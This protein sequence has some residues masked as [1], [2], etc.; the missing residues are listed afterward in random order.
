MS[1]TRIG[2]IG[3]NTGI[4]FA[5]VT[6]IVTLNTANDALSIGATV[7]VGSGNLTVGSG[8]TISSDGD[9]F[10]TGVITATSYSGIDLSDVTGATGDFSIADKIVHTG[11][12]DTAIRFPNTDV[13][14]FETAGA[15]RFSL[16]TNEV[17]VNDPGNDIDFR[18]E[19][20]SDTNLFKVD[21]GNDRIGL[22]VAAPSAKLEVLEDVYVKGSSG[23]GSVGIQIRSGSSAISNQHQIRTGGGSGDQLFIE[24]LGASSAIVSKVA[25][26]ERLRIGPSGQIGIAGANYGT[27]GQV[28]TSGGSG[29]AVSWTTISGTTINANTNNYL[30]TGT[31]TANTLQGESGLTYDGDNLNVS[32]GAHD[33][34]MAITA[35]NNNQ[36]TRLSIIGKASDGTSHTF[37]LNAKRSANRLDIVGGGQTRASI[38]STG[39]FGIGTVAQQSLL[40]VGGGTVSTS[41]KS[42]VHIAPSSGNAMVTLRGGSPQIFFDIT[43][44]GN[45]KIYTDGADLVLYNGTLDSA[46]NEHFRF[47][48][49][50]G[51]TFNGDTAEANAIDDYEEG[52]FT[53]T[54]SFGG[55]SA[56]QGYNYQL[57]RYVKVGTMVHVQIYIYFNDKGSSTGTAEITGFPFTS[58]N[59]TAMYPSANFGY[60]N[61]GSSSSGPGSISHF[62]GYMNPNSSKFNIQRQE[63]NASTPAVNDAQDYNFA[64]NTDFMLNL[65]YISA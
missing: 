4:A 57:G 22:G 58:R 16:G 14:S 36:E 6:T 37:L 56:G 28:L 44:S 7:N 10:F 49:N 40:Q 2:S 53:P 20:D 43:S 18:I 30:I 23:D 3:I 35:A 13:I 59:Q 54:V 63:M 25:G 19:G 41:T 8:V 9:G 46:G 45:P 47:R 27:S 11:D 5:G 29:S 26:S 48:G 50:G 15:D 33:S 32:A 52:A 55:G 60:W 62:I 21:A 61:N 34:G 17:V 12:T 65:T 38:L 1:L 64:N 24:A 51:L 31:G 39:E 42:T